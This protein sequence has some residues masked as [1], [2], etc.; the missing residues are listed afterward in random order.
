MALMFPL[1]L[2]IT[3]VTIV[4]VIWFGGHA[5]SDGSVEIGAL[6]ALMSYVMQILMSVMMR[7]SWP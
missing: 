1:V 7:R 2:V 5:V 6:T 3:N 4:A